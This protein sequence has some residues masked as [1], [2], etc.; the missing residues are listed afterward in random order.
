MLAPIVKG[1]Y[2]IRLFSLLFGLILIVQTTC[3]QN[4]SSFIKNKISTDIELN[5]AQTDKRGI[6]AK[7]GIVYYVEKDMQTVT[8]Y[9]NGKIKWQT[10]IITTCGIPA[11]G[12]PAIRYIKL[13]NG[14]ISVTFGKHSFAS[15]DTSSGKTT[16]LGAD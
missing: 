16:Y 3:A 6:E 12:Q 10:N 8:A 1:Q 13:D 11:V 9:E 2:M 5:F 14:K 7:T 15:I 4:P